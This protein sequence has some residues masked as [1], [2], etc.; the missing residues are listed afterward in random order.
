[1][2]LK[3]NPTDESLSMFGSEYDMFIKY[4]INFQEYKF[5]QKCSKNCSND[6]KTINRTRDMLLFKKLW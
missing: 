3:V 4:L 6:N 5:I 2:K 1:M